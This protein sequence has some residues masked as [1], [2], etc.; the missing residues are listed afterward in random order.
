MN[1]SQTSSGTFKVDISEMYGEPGMNFTS[2]N[3]IVALSQNGTE[4]LNTT[5][6]DGYLGGNIS[7]LNFTDSDTNGY[8]NEGDYFILKG[9]PGVSYV[10]KL[11][12]RGGGLQ[13]EAELHP[14]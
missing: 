4:I 12:L 13:A 11:N 5:L 1:S 2:G 3:I 7:I 14:Y 8:M 6:V 10:L 9:T